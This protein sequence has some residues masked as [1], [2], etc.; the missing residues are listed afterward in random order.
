M[1]AERAA[2]SG[3]GPSGGNLGFRPALRRDLGLLLVLKSAA[4]ALLWWLFFSPTH[5][6]PVDAMSTGRHLALE[7]LADTQQHRTFPQSGDEP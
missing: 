2:A 3:Q 7:R 1:T 6:L 5:R 4:L